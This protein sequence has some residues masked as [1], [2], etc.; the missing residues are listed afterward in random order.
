MDVSPSASN[1]IPL[2][3]CIHCKCGLNNCKCDTFEYNVDMYRPEM[4]KKCCCED[5][6]YY[7]YECAYYDCGDCYHNFVFIEDICNIIIHV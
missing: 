5:D 6:G 2:P 1:Y 4:N 7:C 3:I